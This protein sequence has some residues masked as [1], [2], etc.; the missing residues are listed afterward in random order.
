MENQQTIIGSM[1]DN[2]KVGAVILVEIVG[3]AR[4]YWEARV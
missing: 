2:P 3:G 1:K 4:G